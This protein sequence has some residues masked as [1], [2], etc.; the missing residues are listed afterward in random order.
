MVRSFNPVGQGA[1]YTEQ[2]EHDLN[3]V[4]DCGTLSKL[5]ILEKEI[6]GVFEKGTRIDAVFISHMDADHI[7]GLDCL[8]N[9]CDVENIFVP[10]LSNEDKIEIL[11]KNDSDGRLTEFNEKFV[12]D[13]QATVDEK[14]QDKNMRTRIKFVK[15]YNRQ[16]DTPEY[17]IKEVNMS[18]IESGTRLTFNRMWVYVPFNFSRSER[19]KDLI[20][21]LI[22][23]GIKVPENGKEIR[24]LLA[25]NETRR[26]MR[27]IY[28]SLDGN[29]NENS[30]VVYSG[31]PIEDVKQFRTMCFKNRICTS[32]FYPSCYRCCYRLKP[33]CV[34]MGDYNLSSEEQWKQFM[35]CFNE[36]VKK[37]D[38]IQVPHHGSYKSYNSKLTELDITE[39]IVSAG[40]KNRYHHPNAMVLKDMIFKNKNISIVTEYASSRVMYC[41]K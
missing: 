4:Y 21:K 37:C 12:L 2:F 14:T 24:A 39:Y 29:I 13:P 30:M 11:L 20:D 18:E 3:V 25:D 16:D 34:Y 26:K 9:Y 10:L 7:N 19:C 5:D 35:E 33:G 8:L 23:T 38:V 32:Q 6:K 36:Y 31:P 28:K 22:Q 40:A 1:F 27:E 41:I 15:A 17:H